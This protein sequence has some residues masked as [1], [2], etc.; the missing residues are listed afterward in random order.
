MSSAGGFGPSLA[1]KSGVC[2]INVAIDQSRHHVTP[3]SG[4]NPP[5]YPYNSAVESHDL[6]DGAIVFYENKESVH[7]LGSRLKVSSTCAGLGDG[8]GKDHKSVERQKMLLKMSLTPVGVIISPNNATQG[9]VADMGAVAAVSGV[10]SIPRDTAHGEP[11]VYQ[12]GTVVYADLP[13]HIAS[14]QYTHSGKPSVKHGLVLTT[15]PPWDDIRHGILTR[16]LSAPDASHPRGDMDTIN[17]A[18]ANIVYGI[19]QLG[20][21]NTVG[22]PEEKARELFRADNVELSHFNRMMSGFLTCVDYERKWRIGTV[23]KDRGHA[24]DVLIS[25]R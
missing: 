14:D 24:V 16:I 5:L 15:R 7:G 17:A 25:S 18:I 4:E 3:L 21:V 6:R 12:P 8:S 1:N 23:V 10:V 19:H 11:K 20:K 2:A 22:T 13:H 9:D